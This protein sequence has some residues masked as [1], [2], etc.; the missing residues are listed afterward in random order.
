MEKT[1]GDRIRTARLRKG[2][3]QSDVAAVLDCAPTS[4]TN[5]ENGKIEPS[6]EVL[7]RLCEVLEI[8][9]LDLLGKTHSFNEIAAIAGKPAHERAYEER[10]ALN[11]SYEI[12][13]KL[14]PAEMRRQETKR[15]EK[16]AT[17]IKDV[18]LL[19]RFGGSIEKKD[20]E[21]L[22]NDYEEYGA[23][24]T[25]ILFAF[26]ALT[27]ESKATILDVLR[28]LISVPGNIQPLAENMQTATEY[29]GNK[30]ARQAQAIRAEKGDGE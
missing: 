27:S 7:S 3:K 29:T 12:L 14:L 11:F 1:V 15:I 25:D 10:I 6:V 21:T 13:K 17:F 18:N 9:P 8:S 5:W 23:A 30:L 2:L 28:G 22:F 20:I 19:E 4:L 24:D 16:T 26:H